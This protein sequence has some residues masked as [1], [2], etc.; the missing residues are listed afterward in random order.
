VVL[1]PVSLVTLFSR[2]LVLEGSALDSGL[3]VLAFGA[4]IVGAV[5]RFWSTLYV[6]GRKEKSLVDEGP[7]SACRNPLYMGSF[8][9]AASVGLFLKSVTFALGL[10][11]VTAFYIGVTVPTEEEHLRERYGE[12]YENYCRRVPRYWPRF[13]MAHSPEEIAVSLKA[14]RREW[15]RAFFGW[16]W[17]PVAVEAISH[18]RSEAWWPHLFRLW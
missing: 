14:L 8:L 2:P 13:S 11:A 18:L 10:A 4:F 15:K 5:F 1:V 12:D 6:G 16:F 3:D 17:L 9:L 7:Y